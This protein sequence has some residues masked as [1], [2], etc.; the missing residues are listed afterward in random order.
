MISHAFWQTYLGGR[1]SAIGGS[2]TLLDQPFTIVGVAPPS[3]TGVEVGRTFD[4]A[5]A[6]CSAALW[7]PVSSNGTAGG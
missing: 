3:F 5:L 4:V 2:L 6:V 1:E 7:A